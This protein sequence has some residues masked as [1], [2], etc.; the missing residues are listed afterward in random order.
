[1]KKFSENNPS[2][3]SYLT[4]MRKLGKLHAATE[5]PKARLNIVDGKTIEIDGVLVTTTT[6]S[7][8]YRQLLTDS[9]EALTTLLFGMKPLKEIPEV[10]DEVR[11]MTPGYSSIKPSN[12][13]L[14]L[15]YRSPDFRKFLS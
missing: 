15:L 11:N 3:F 4:L 10:Y 13:L 1:M 9:K 8:L 5:I 2:P 12:E 7:A 6:L 14:Y